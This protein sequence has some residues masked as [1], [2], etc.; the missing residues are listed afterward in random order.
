M[1]EQTTLADEIA[2]MTIQME[3]GENPPSYE[4]AYHMLLRAMMEIRG[5]QYRVNVLVDLNKQG[6]KDVHP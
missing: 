2:E 4:D 6:I 5:L 1:E 3:S